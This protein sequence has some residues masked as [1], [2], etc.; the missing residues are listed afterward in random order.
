MSLQTLTNF[1][2]PRD[3][4]QIESCTPKEKSSSQHANDTNKDNNEIT[5]STCSEIL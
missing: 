4:I 3:K 5:H 2:K 1:F